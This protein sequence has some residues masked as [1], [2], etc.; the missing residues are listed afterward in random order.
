MYINVQ[1]TIM[2]IYVQLCN[3]IEQH[4]IILGDEF[5]CLSFFLINGHITHWPLPV[6]LFISLS[7]LMSISQSLLL[8]SE[9]IPAGLGLSLCVISAGSCGLINGSGGV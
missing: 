5:P 7:L 2:Y 3:F 8:H 1:Y 9:L 6:L 4:G